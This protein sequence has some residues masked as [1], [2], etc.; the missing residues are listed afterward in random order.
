MEESRGSTGEKK[1]PRWR[2][3][4]FLAIG[5]VAVALFAS[6]CGGD[7][8]GK[9]VAGSTTSTNPAEKAD[10]IAFS[11]CMREH[12]VTGFPDL[13]A[14]GN[15]VG[16]PGPDAVDGKSPVFQAAEKACAPLK[17]VRKSHPNMSKYR[18]D[19]IKYSKCMRDKGIAN[20]PDPNAKGDL[21]LDPAKSGIDPESE[22]FTTAEK[23]CRPLLVVPPGARAPSARS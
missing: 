13:D 1:A 4:A 21:E 3:P 16:T 12:G 7:E 9:G 14:D 23:A 15:S 20:F 10:P 17:P 5:C 19:Q 6:A 22:Q 2:G 8:S 18:D 11:K